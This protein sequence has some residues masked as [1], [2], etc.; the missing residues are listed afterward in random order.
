MIKPGS[1]GVFARGLV[2]FDDFFAG[3]VVLLGL[4][5]FVVATS[6][7]YDPGW[8]ESEEVKASVVCLTVRI[9]EGGVM[10]G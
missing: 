2:G 7:V 6:L 4:P 1:D 5:I 9:G 10:D 3:K 8:R